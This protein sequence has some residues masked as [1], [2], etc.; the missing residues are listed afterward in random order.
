MKFVHFFVLAAAL[1]TSTAL[2]SAPAA[3]QRASNAITWGM[4]S[5]VETLDPYA[6]SKRTTQLVVRNVVENLMVRD[7]ATGKALPA[8]ATAWRWVDNTTLR[9]ELRKGVQSCAA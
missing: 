5:E 3:A 2:V 8:L 7:P 9:I 6:T 1:A 4:N